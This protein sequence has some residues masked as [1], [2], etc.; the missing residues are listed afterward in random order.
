MTNANSQRRNAHKRG[1]KEITLQRET[2]INGLFKT[3][4]LIP[5]NKEIVK[6]IQAFS[7]GQ[8]NFVV[9]IFDG[10]FNGNVDVV[11][12]FTAIVVA[13]INL[14]GNI[15]FVLRTYGHRMTDYLT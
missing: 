14:Q 12:K 9:A 15:A 7:V 10:A 11:W 13:T 5:M 8:Y 6:L 2:Q 4:A 3:T 1:K